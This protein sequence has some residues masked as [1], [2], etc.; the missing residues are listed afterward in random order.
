M[1]N[2]PQPFLDAGFTDGDG[3]K[4]PKYGGYLYI[5][6]GEYRV[7]V[8]EDGCLHIYLGD[9]F[10]EICLLRFPSL[11]LARQAA[12]DLLCRLHGVPTKAEREVE[13]L[14][15]E[16]EPVFKPAPLDIVS[17]SDV[18]GGTPCIAGTRI[19]AEFLAAFY[20]SNGQD[21]ELV[22]GFYRDSGITA[23]HVLLAVKFRQENGDGWPKGESPK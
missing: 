19:P 12:E 1:T 18:M 23:N 9:C 16:Y 11:S 4:F 5:D 10:E 22:A 6:S 3:W 20:E 17:F 8:E 2:W 21:A 13:R 7:T 14:R 15:S